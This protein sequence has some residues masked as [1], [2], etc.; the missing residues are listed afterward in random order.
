[1]ISFKKTKREY[2]SKINI[3]DITGNKKNS[4]KQ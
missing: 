1:M 3:K 4:V 2:Y